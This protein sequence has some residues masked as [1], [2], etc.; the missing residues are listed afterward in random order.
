MNECKPMKIYVAGPYSS[1]IKEETEKNVKHALDVGI[2]LYEK[3]HYP[4]IPHLTHYLDIQSRK[5]RPR[6]LT[7][8]DYMSNDMAWLQIA[9]AMFFIGRSRGADIEYNIARDIGIKIYTNISDVPDSFSKR[10][11]VR[12]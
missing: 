3:G 10:P 5:T 9:D 7:W 4:Y 6:P 8:L 11:E 12:I 2:H 1:E